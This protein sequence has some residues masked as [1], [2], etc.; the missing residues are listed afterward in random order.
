M[1]EKIQSFPIPIYK[2]YLK[3]D[4]RTNVDTKS[5]SIL[6]ETK[7][8]CLRFK[9]LSLRDKSKSLATEEKRSNI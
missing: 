1:G 3:M 7:R 4:C 8:R 6:S 9:V 2:N 5:V